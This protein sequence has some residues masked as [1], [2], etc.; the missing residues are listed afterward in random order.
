MDWLVI[1]SVNPYDGRYEF[2]LAGD[3]FT[4]R[5][6]GWVK[7]LAGYL[8]DNLEDGLDGAATRS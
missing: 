1:E 7:R 5:E 4:T 8:P 3:Q 6:W 2:D